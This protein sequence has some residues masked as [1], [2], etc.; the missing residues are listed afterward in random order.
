MPDETVPIIIFNGNNF[1]TEDE[2][3]AITKYIGER[4]SHGQPVMYVVSKTHPG[5]TARKV[6]FTGETLN[7]F[8][9]TGIA[10]KILKDCLGE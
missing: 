2:K 5:F 4:W 10:E 9:A 6:E 3:N 7:D 8:E 1:I